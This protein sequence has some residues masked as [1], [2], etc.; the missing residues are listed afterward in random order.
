MRDGRTVASNQGLPDASWERR[1]RLAAGGLLIS[2]C[3]LVRCL[4]ALQSKQLQE[5][6]C[7]LL[8]NYTSPVRSCVARRPGSQPVPGTFEISQKS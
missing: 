7:K 5:S 2:G 8:S 4:L 3:H 6:N 1:E